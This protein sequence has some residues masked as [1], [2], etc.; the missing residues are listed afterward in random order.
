[1]NKSIV[2]NPLHRNIVSHHQLTHCADTG[3]VLEPFFS[4]A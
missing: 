2:L 3:S 4:H 1:M